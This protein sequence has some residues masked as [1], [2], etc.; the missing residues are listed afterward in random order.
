MATHLFNAMAPLGSRE[1]GTVGA[2]MR[3]DGLTAGLIADAVHVHPASLTIAARTKGQDGIF[4]VSDAMSP[5]GTDMTEFQLNGRRVVVKD[6]QCRTE[7]GT[8]AGSVLTMDAGGTD[9]G[10]SGRRAA[11]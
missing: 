1:P 11:R 8:L 3:L 2:V 10:S 6:G 4:L 9:D 5:I 7:D